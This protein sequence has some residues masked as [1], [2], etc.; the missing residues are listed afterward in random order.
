[1]LLFIIFSMDF[2]SALRLVFTSDGVVSEVVRALMTLV[3]IKNRSRKLSHKHDRIRVRR[4]R[5]F[6]FLPILLTT[7]SLTFCL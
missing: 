1:M 3:K 2:C 6:P 7:L 5:T 4:I